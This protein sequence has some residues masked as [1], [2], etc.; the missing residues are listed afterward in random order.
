MLP[1]EEQARKAW[2]VS[3]AYVRHSAIFLNAGIQFFRQAWVALHARSSWRRSVRLGEMVRETPDLIAG[4]I[5]AVRA[6]TERPFGVNLIPAATD[7]ALLEAELATCFEKRSFARAT[8]GSRTRDETVPRTCP[9]ASNPCE[10]RDDNDNRRG[11]G[12]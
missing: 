4:E 12:L 5:E 2:R 6:R 7:P 9:P 11:T 1:N 8:W 3:R 10:S